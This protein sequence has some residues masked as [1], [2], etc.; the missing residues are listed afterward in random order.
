MGKSF[1]KFY[2]KITKQ[3]FSLFTSSSL[4]L[5]LAEFRLPPR[6]RLQLMNKITAEQRENKTKGKMYFSPICTSARMLKWISV[7]S[8]SYRLQWQSLFSNFPIVNLNYFS[9][10][11]YVA[12]CCDLKNSNFNSKVEK[13]CKVFIVD[14]LYFLVLFYWI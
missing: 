6:Q 11:Y 2:F 9:Q 14:Y 10:L 13:N 12:F 4:R 7:F 5:L 1:H 8:Q 3:F